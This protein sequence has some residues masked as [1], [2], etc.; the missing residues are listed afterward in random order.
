[1]DVDRPPRPRRRPAHHDEPGAGPY[2]ATPYLREFAL[3]RFPVWIFDGPEKT[4]Y[5]F[6]VYGEAAVKA[7]RDMSGTF[8]TQETRSR[9]PDPARRVEVA[10][11][12]AEHLPSALGPELVSKTC[13]CDMPPDRNFILDRLPGHPRVSV[14]V[15]AGHAAKFASLIGRI[16]VDLVST[17]RAEYPISAFRADR[18]AL[19]DPDYSSDFRFTEA[20]RA[21]EGVS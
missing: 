20:A 5:G 15:G 11:F 6:P 12:P 16:L 9:E 8:V 3:D 1:V 10:E 18:P 19:T 7:A 14:F 17:G 13:V 21:V 2:F 4:F